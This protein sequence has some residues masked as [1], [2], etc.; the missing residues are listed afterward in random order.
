MKKSSFFDDEVKSK[1]NKKSSFFEDLPEQP[2]RTR[3]VLS[4]GPKG[5]V[6][7][8]RDLGDLAQLPSNWLVEKIAPEF[9]EKKKQALQK[10]NEFLEEKLLPTQ[11]GQTLEDILEFTGQMAPTVALGEASIPMKVAQAFTG[12][13]TKKGLEELD[14]PEWAQDVGA[15]VSTAIPGAIK[16]LSSKALATSSKNKEMYDFLK[17]KGLSDK[18]ITP[19]LQSEAKVNLLGPLASKGGRS[20]KIAEDIRSS[21]GPIYKDIKTQ[22]ATK[23][24][25]KNKVVDFEDKLLNKLDDLHYSYRKSIDK[26]VKRLLNN[27]VTFKSIR[28]FEREINN[29]IG[30]LEGGK[31]EIGILKEVTDEAKQWI[32]S[33]LYK[34]LKMVNKAYG[35]GLSIADKL[36]PKGIE[37]LIGLGQIGSKVYSI[38]SLAKNIGGKSL[39]REILTNPRLQQIH[40]KLLKSINDQKYSIS[41]KLAEQIEKEIEKSSQ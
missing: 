7:G 33:D 24:L 38:A 13:S 30:G 40:R 25:P 41:L 1:S 28:E 36:D 37:G 18:Q 8:V 11:K 34:D 19:I 3:S 31:A 9:A 21:L 22:G 20:T 17:S 16:N 23:F 15:G 39:A 29:K 6:K 10:G 35:K 4:A 27:P 12:G 32:D 26:D 14:F 5:V 2:S